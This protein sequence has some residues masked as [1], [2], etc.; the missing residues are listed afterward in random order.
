MR[1]SGTRFTG[2]HFTEWRESNPGRVVNKS[3]VEKESRLPHRGDSM[4][5][6]ARDNEEVDGLETIYANSAVRERIFDYL[7]GDEG[8]QPTAYFLARCDGR[9]PTEIEQIPIESWE[10]ALEVPGDLARS[11]ADRESLIVHLDIEYVNFDSPEESFLD[12]WRIFKL[13]EPV[14][15][16]VEEELSRCGIRPLHLLTGQGHH[17]VWR[18]PLDSEPCRRLAEELNPISD[19]NS[20]SLSSPHPFKDRA[21]GGLGLLMEFLAHRIKL[22]SAPHSAIPV[23]LTAVEVG[24]LKSG[25]REMISIDVSEY[26]DPLAERIIRIPFT[27]YEK[28]WLSGMVE[29]LDLHFLVPKFVTLPLHEIDVAQAL[30]LRQTSTEVIA[31]ARRS[32]VRIPNQERGM[33][34]LIEKYCSSPLREFHEHYYEVAPVDN[35]SGTEPYGNDTADTLPPCIATILTFPNDLLLKPACLQL[36]TRFLLANGWHPRHVAKLVES[37]FSNP[38]FNWLPSYWEKYS[39]QMRADF[40]VRLFSGQI[41]T[42]LDG[43]ID[44]NCVSTQEKHYCPGAPCQ[45]NLSNHREK[46]HS[47]NP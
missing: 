30:V 44:F 39:A 13:Q 11:L 46:L 27:H 43:G 8:R 36:V 38:A 31:L 23:D 28:P 37:K 20:E 17:F 33:S 5:D 35:V 9:L 4:E 32:V 12:P 40:Y 18:I 3:S 42:H 14:V 29:R 7:G 21:F 47:D 41:M 2:Q 6:A 25:R 22:L 16:V 34:R 26:G 1:F 10:T 45:N 19:D 15:T 24:Q